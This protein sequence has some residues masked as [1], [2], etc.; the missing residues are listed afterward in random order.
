MPGS[1]QCTACACIKWRIQNNK[2]SLPLLLDHGSFKALLT[3]VL[4]PAIKRLASP[5]Q[6]FAEAVVVGLPLA[7]PLP[8]RVA[9]LA[10]VLDGGRILDL[11]DGLASGDVGLELAAELPLHA[12]L[13]DGEVEDLDQVWGQV[14]GVLLANLERGAVLGLDGVSILSQLGEV[15]GEVLG[16]EAEAGGVSAV[17]C[18]SVDVVGIHGVAAQLNGTIETGLH[19]L[20]DRGVTD[21]DVP[22]VRVRTAERLAANRLWEVGVVIVP[23]LDGAS[24]EVA[25]D[26][27]TSF[28]VRCSIPLADNFLGR[29]ELLFRDKGEGLGR[30]VKWGMPSL[31]AGIRGGFD[32]YFEHGDH[33]WV[34]LGVGHVDVPNRRTLGD[35]VIRRIVL[36]GLMNANL[37]LG[38]GLKHGEGILLLGRRHEGVSTE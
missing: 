7:E 19:E 14:G 6:D 12:G 24:I 28:L 3:A 23:R 31:C 9:E 35:K 34:I 26:S 38:T 30:R 4:T 27:L 16:L 29:I 25:D 20:E 11:V 13:E 10:L 32:T 21:I 1:C 33:V 2:A 15:L 8:V 36:D 17:R 37:P 22:F 18:P 5:F